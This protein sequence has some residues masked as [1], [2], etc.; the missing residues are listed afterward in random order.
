MNYV[1]GVWGQ[2][3]S[4]TG[5]FQREDEFEMILEGCIRRS[6]SDKNGV[7]TGRFQDRWSTVFTS[8]VT[9]GVGHE[10]EGHELSTKA[11]EAGSGKV[12]KDQVCFAKKLLLFSFRQ[13]R[14]IFPSLAW[15]PN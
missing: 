2:G 14:T 8:F 15:K 6:R 12:A 1:F 13:C 3:I 4:T 9:K 7:D 10:Q 5:K 11:R